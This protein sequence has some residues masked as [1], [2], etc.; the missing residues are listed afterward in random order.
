MKH[1]IIISLTLFFC[2]SITTAQAEDP[3][4]SQKELNTDTIAEISSPENLPIEIVKYDNAKIQNVYTQIKNKKAKDGEK[5]YLYVKGTV[6]NTTM[7]TLSEPTVTAQFIDEKGKSITRHYGT[8]IPRM[9]R[10]QGNK[11]GHFTIKAP[12]DPSLSLLKLS[13][14]WAGK[15]KE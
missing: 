4:N 15:N 12:Y 3:T 5:Q 14:N 9:I 10:S 8:V 6:K 13:L 1:L 7:G 2:F 11:K